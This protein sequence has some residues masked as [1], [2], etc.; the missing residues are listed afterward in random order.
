MHQN[1][2]N[3]TAKAYIVNLYKFTLSSVSLH[4]F[5]SILR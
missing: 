2:V 3:L 1:F 4:L 5:K